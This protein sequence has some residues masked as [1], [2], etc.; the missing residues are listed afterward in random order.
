MNIIHKYKEFG[1]TICG[2]NM[3]EMKPDEILV[4]TSIDKEVT[5]PKC[6]GE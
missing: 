2:K 6:K 1:I 3:H 4:G 5:C